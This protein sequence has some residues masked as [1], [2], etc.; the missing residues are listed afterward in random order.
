MDTHGQP[1][2]F[3]PYPTNRVVGTIVDARN[4]RAATE[5]LLGAGFEPDEIDILHGEKDL[6]RLDPT[7]EDHGVLAQLQRSLIRTAGPADEFKNL[8]RHVDDVRAGRYVIMV[9]AREREKRRVAADILNSHGAEFVGF[10]GRWA[11]QSLDAAPVNSTD[12]GARDK[13]LAEEETGTANLEANKATVTA[14]YDLM[15]NQS[16]PAAAV[17]RYVGDTYTQHNPTVGE[18]KDAFIEYFERMAR[19]HPGKRV[20]FLR[21]LADGAFV[22]LH[23]CQHWPNAGD[24]AGIDIFRLDDDGKIVEHRD[25]R[26]KIP[27]QSANP[28]TMF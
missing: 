4:A 23:C 27:P 11:W 21:V 26:Q 14:F 24:W 10:Y 16:D 18:S 13:E 20:E 17:R 1:D 2:D 19:E 5:A 28:N 9:L 25:V 22:V 7:G 12:R 15:F 3:I 8:S 6:H